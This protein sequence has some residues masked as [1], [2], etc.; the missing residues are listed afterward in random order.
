MDKKAVL[1]SD[2]QGN[3]SYGFD[4]RL[5]FD[6]TDG[7]ADFGDDNVGFGLL[8]HAVNELFDLVRD[9]GNNLNGGAQVLSA[10]LF[11]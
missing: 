6:V 9:V 10:T 4:K 3:L 5:G 2:L 11:I 8:T 7:T 1:S